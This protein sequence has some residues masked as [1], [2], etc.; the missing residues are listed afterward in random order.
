M[1]VYH[2]DAFELDTAAH[3]L[4]SR[5]VMLQIEPK[6]YAVL[7]CLLE[8]WPDCVTQDALLA[9]VWP[10]YGASRYALHTALNNMRRAIGQ[11]PGERYPVECLHTHGY[12]I[13]PEVTV[14]ESATQPTERTPPADPV[15][16]RFYQ[17][18]AMQGGKGADDAAIEADKA[19]LNEHKRFAT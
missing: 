4:T 16:W 15:A 3:T 14:S 17:G 8:R 11:G 2:F 5:G 9:A 12:R 13:K 1:P 6:P 7:R 18:C 10:G 19:L